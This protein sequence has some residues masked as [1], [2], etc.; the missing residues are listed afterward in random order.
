MLIAAH[1][2][3]ARVKEGLK[4]T[5]IEVAPHTLLVVVVEATFF[6]ALRAAE[7]CFLVVLGP[8]VDAPRSGIKGNAAH[9]PRGREA[10]KVL[11]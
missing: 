7:A 2:R 9:A 11:V 3:D 5:A 10:K 8:D 4:L 6:A 1:A